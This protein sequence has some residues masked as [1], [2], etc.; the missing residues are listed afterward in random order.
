MRSKVSNEG[1]FLVKLDNF[2]FL[3]AFQLHEETPVIV[4][5]LKNYRYLDPNL[6]PTPGAPLAAA[7]QQLGLGAGRGRGQEKDGGEAR[8]A[9]EDVP[10]SAIND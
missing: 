6:P 8:G 2:S 3:S 5:K 7:A 1:Y 4:C 10:G 9:A